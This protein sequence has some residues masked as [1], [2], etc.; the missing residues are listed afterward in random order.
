M[1]NSITCPSCKARFVEVGNEK[2]Y[3]Q[4]LPALPQSAPTPRMSAPSVPAPLW[5]S[6][7]GQRLMQAGVSAGVALVATHNTGFAI[8]TGATVWFVS[9]VGGSGNWGVIKDLLDR[10]K[11]GRIDK[12]DLM[13]ILG[14][15][16]DDSEPRVPDLPVEV[17][18]GK[19][20]VYGKIT[21]TT[22]EQLTEAAV[23]MF[24]VV[25]QDKPF[26][27]DR[28]GGVFGSNFSNVQKEMRKLGLLEGNKNAG[29]K[30][31][32]DGKTFLGRYHPTAKAPSPTPNE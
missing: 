29:Y 20:T 21:G 13:D 1:T 16:W 9:L 10:N 22:R 4:S 31:T 26:S 28:V 6:K 11:D 5:A 2:S 27:R 14:N 12:S 18:R 32:T 19:K 8:G 30:L 17:V 3:A 15:W 23:I 24:T 7:T 25:N